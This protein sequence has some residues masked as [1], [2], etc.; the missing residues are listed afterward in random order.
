[1]GP[2]A[3]ALLG[4]TPRHCAQCQAQACLASAHTAATPKACA[5][6]SIIRPCP[7]IRRR[8]WCSGRRL[9]G[10]PWRAR[11]ARIGCG[12]KGKWASWVLRITDPMLQPAVPSRQP[13]RM[14]NSA[15]AGCRRAPAQCGRRPPSP[16]ARGLT[17][18]SSS[19]SM[20][21]SRSSSESLSIWNSPGPRRA[22][23][24]RAGRSGLGRIG[25]GAAVGTT[26]AAEAGDR[27]QRCQGPGAGAG[28][29]QRAGLFL[30]AAPFALRPAIELRHC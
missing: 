1:M 3:G 15:R 18:S 23:G 17:S 30:A 25:R 20:T 24:W 9:A 26:K 6:C 10:P 16:A 19:S 12:S 7:A 11:T 27:L 28:G 5:P 14:L 29:A 2:G 22:I 4:Q 13:W 8:K 21:P